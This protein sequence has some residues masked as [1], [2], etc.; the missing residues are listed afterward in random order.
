[1][2]NLSARHDGAKSK[3]KNLVL[4]RARADDMKF[5]LELGEVYK[6]RDHF[7]LQLHGHLNNWMCYPV[8]AE[9]DGLVVGFEVSEI[10][11]GGRGVMKRSARVAP[12]HRKMGLL[13]IMDFHLDDWARATLP[14]LKHELM[15]VVDKTYEKVAKEFTHL[16]YSLAWRQDVRV[17]LF[18]T[19]DFKGVDEK[20]ETPYTVSP[21]THEDLRH[22][23]QCSAVVD[24]LFPNKLLLLYGV[25]CGALAENIFYMKTPGRDVF[26]SS[27]TPAMSETPTNYWYQ[28]NFTDDMITTAD[29]LTFAYNYT[30]DLGLIYIIDIYAAEGCPERALRE[31]IR[32]HLRTICRLNRGGGL[33][34]LGVNQHVTVEHVLAILKEHGIETPLPNSEI[35]NVLVKRDVGSA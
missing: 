23:F 4:R 18:D 19:K 12:S 35:A 24:K 33:F 3:L 31:H 21:L 7:N 8:V 15:S 11:D 29:M 34:G 26:G 17:L 9:I 25:G 14:G 32:Y 28:R 16:G 10:I 30:G 20:Q 1:A 2:S 5:L 6:G 22:L 13:H 27:A